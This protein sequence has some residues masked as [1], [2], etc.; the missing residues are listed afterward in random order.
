MAGVRA[1]GPSLGP[2]DVEP[3]L[4]WLRAAV[5]RLERQDAECNW[6]DPVVWAA[7]REMARLL[8]EDRAYLRLLE[9]AEPQEAGPHSARHPS[10]CA[11]AGR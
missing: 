5:R 2:Q 4:E 6:P 9:P 10:E 1:D 11:R 7:V 8:L 3:P